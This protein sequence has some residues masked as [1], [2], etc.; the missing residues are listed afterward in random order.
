MTIS[1]MGT[2]LNKIMR[3]CAPAINPK[4][5]RPA[6][7]Y[8]ELQTDGEGNGCATAL[9]GFVLAQTRFECMGDKG[10]MLIVHGKVD[11]DAEV[12]LTKHGDTT[13]IRIDNYT[14][15][16]ELPPVE[17]YVNHR[18]VTGNATAQEKVITLAVAHDVLKRMIKSAKTKEGWIALHIYGPDDGIV[19]Q[20]GDAVGMIMPISHMDGSMH[21]EFWTMDCTQ[22]EADDE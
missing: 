5:A 8:I 6:L 19:V 14:R 15:S 20:T 21:P 1:L 4:E 9:D 3:V 17:D 16:E 12:W 7:R 2:E 22:E 11:D 18:M 10:K 13:T